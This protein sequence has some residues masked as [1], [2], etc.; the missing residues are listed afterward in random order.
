MILVAPQGSTLSDNKRL[1]HLF[2]RMYPEMYP[3]Y[4]M[5]EWWVRIPGSVLVRAPFVVIAVS[6]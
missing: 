1:L 2:H 4:G 5:L 6:K 3:I